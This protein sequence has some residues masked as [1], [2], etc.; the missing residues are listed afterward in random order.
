MDRTRLCPDTVKWI[1]D[2]V[3]RGGGCKTMAR[4]SERQFIAKEIDALIE[5]HIEVKREKA[6]NKLTEDDKKVLG[7]L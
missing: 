5:D 4:E 7:L 2:Y 1:A 3:R 6:L